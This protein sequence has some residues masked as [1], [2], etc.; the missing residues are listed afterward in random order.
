MLFTG[1]RKN[2]ALK[3]KWNDIEELDGIR[4]IIL[5]DTKNHRLHYLAVTEAIQAVL[6]KASNKTPHVF[7]SKQKADAPASDE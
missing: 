7:P 1:L 4:Y 3:L 6:S 5:R 2:E